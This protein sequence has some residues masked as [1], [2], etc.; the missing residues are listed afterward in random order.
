MDADEDW[1]E[2]SRAR[3]SSEV[4]SSIEVGGGKGGEEEDSCVECDMDEGT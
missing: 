2:G 1:E 3:W 4:S